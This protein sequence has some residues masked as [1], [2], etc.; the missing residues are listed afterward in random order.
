MVGLQKEDTMPITYNV[1]AEGHFIHAIAVS[2]LTPKEFVDFEVA[3]A[4]DARIKPPVSE[5][6][7]IAADAFAHITM[8]DMKEV[9]KRRGEVK[10]LPTPHRCAIALG[11]LDDHSWDLAKFYEG[12]VMLHSPESVIVFARADIARRWIGFENIQP[13]K[14]DAGDGK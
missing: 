13:N 10:G 7:E 14:P 5:L 8:D 3:H 2:P 1:Y 6:F 12:M 11:S 9:I 4:I